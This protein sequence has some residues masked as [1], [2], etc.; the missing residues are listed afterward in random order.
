MHYG[1]TAFTMNGQP[2]MIPRQAGANIGNAM[3]LSPTDITEVRN[4]YGCAA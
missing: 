4:L 2:T 3:Q 1:T